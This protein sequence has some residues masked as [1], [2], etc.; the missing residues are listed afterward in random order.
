MS[1]TKTIKLTMLTDPKGAVCAVCGDPNVTCHTVNATGTEDYWQCEEHSMM[2]QVDGEW[3]GIKGC[4]EHGWDCA[5][6]HTG[7]DCEEKLIKT[8]ESFLHTRDFDWA[9][10]VFGKLVKL[11]GIK[12]K[13]KGAH[14]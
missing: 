11:V 4:C 6:P 2:V 3:V 14:H 7:C 1:D 5:H 10:E 12:R 13:K 8:I 9:Q